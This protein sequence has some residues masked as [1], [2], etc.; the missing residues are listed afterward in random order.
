MKTHTPGP[1]YRNQSFALVVCA[2]F[3]LLL[4][5]RL[6]LVTGY[7][8]TVSAAPDAL[9]VPPAPPGPTPVYAEPPPLPPPAHGHAS[10]QPQF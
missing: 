4:T 5:A 8:R 6:V 2:F 9:A 1:F 10:R 7:P 3:G